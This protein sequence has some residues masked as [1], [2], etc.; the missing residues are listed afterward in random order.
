MLDSTK[1]NFSQKK[2]S[3][4][5]H[6]WNSKKWYEED[7]GIII[8]QHAKEIWVDNIVKNPSNNNK[9]I[10]FHENIEL[11]EDKTVQDRKAFYAVDNLGNRIRGFIPPTYGVDYTFKLNINGIKITTT[12]PSNW[13]FDYTNGIITFENTP[14]TGKVTISAYEY[15]GRTFQQYLDSEFNS[16]AMGLLGLDT[17]QYEYIIQHNMGTFDIE[18][19]I[20]VFDDVDGTKYWK[21]D[22][23]P[24]ILID[25]NRVKLQLTEA[26]PIRFI[27]KSY[28]IPDWL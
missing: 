16:V 8:F 4:K 28:E 24:L 9:L 13:I 1:I 19:T 14:P 20:Y 21:K 23:I 27:I 7:D 15:V 10:K 26:Q 6:T 3:G 5:Q 25:E 12:D 17:P 18:V 22:V 2:L 11:F